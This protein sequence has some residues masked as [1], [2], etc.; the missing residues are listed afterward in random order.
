[1]RITRRHLLALTSASAAAATVCAGGIAIRWWDQP[2]GVGYQALSEH[3]AAFVRAFGGAAFPG[4][5]VIALDG[6]DADLDRFFDAMLAAMPALTGNLLKLLIQALDGE[7]MLTH[8]ARY[9]TLR[10]QIQ[11]EQLEALRQSRVVAVRNAVDSLIVLLGMGY[12]THPSVAPLMS[13]WHRC[14]YGR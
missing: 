1:M 11:Q 4:G 12:T 3:E 2:A 14:G 10:R 9:T 7:T 6:S 5:A 13:Q 8:G